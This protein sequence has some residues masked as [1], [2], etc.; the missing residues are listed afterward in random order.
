MQV[1]G[2][3]IVLFCLGYLLHAR[4]HKWT[5]PSDKCIQHNPD[6]MNIQDSSI[7]SQNVLTSLTL[8]I[9]PVPFHHVYMRTHTV[10]TVSRLFC[11]WLVSPFLELHINVIIP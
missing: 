5:F 4:E 2:V 6:P 3:C 11:H 7:T 1:T 9:I 10:T 8:T